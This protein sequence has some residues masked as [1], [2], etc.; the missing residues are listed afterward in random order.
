M[1]VTGTV[2]LHYFAGFGGGRKG[3][4][5]GIASRKTCMATHFAIFNPP[6]IGGR[7]PRRHRRGLERV[8][9]GEIPRRTGRDQGTADQTDEDADQRTAPAPRGQAGRH[10][11]WLAL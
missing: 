7:Q 1:I 5:P 10:L 6:E 11:P 2:S 8:A 4:V 3:L 9:A